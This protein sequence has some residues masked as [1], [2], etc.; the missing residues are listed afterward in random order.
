[1][2]QIYTTKLFKNGA[3]Q[4]VRLPAEFR[5]SSQEVYIFRDEITGDIVLSEKPRPK[6]WQDFFSALSVSEGSDA[7]MAERPMNTVPQEKGL[8]DDEAGK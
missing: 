3:S 4:A 5:F 7:F 8:F 6:V 2:S 1:M